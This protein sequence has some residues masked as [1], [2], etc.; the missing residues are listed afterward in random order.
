[1]SK[2]LSILYISSEVEPFAKTGGLADVAGA[3]P[4]VIREF[5]HDIR[6]FLPKYGFVGERKFNI[7]DVI[8]LRD[9][10]VSLGNK[11]ELASIKSSF[12]TNQRIKV[13]VYFFDLPKH[14]SRDGIYFDPNSKKDYPDND[15]RF[16]GFCRGALE[17]LKRLGWKPDI[18][19]CND[20]Q[21]GLIPA[22]LKTIY[23]DDPFFNK[24]KTVFT[25]HN[26][27]YQGVFPKSSFAKTG[28]PDHLFDEEKG[29]AT[30]DV[31][32]FLKAGIQFADVLTTVSNRYAEEISSNEEYGYGLTELLKKRRKDLHGILNG[33][34]YSV[35]DP[36]IDQLIP[37][38]YTSKTIQ[39]KAENKKV[40]LQTFKLPANDSVPVIGI[41][42]RLVDQKGFDLIHDI[43][44]EV[45]K[46]NL[47]LV[48][49]GTGER[50][51]HNFLSELALKYPEKVGVKLTFD[52]DLAHLIEAGSD[53]FL[54]PSRY[55]P[56]GLNQIYSMRYGTIPIV[57]AT[58]GLDDTVEDFDP[59]NGKGTG[60]KFVPYDGRA[61]LQTIKRALSLFQDEKAWNKTIR[62]AMEQDFSWEKSAKQYIALYKKILKK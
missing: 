31:V 32:N 11:T 21:T 26:I 39:E 9:I 58:G 49:L 7:Y 3:F 35:W 5:G 41:I 6:I 54:M 52:N 46:N 1:M 53:M 43:A 50:R 61:L 59:K 13:Q 55:E 62:N 30:G 29:I 34:D 40:L 36:S 47:I 28:L 10:P 48:V 42:S 18:I 25:I 51:Y 4:Q 60:F 8:R 24:V 14:F 20:W 19:H 27:A 12:I 2:S 23:R 33:V 22:Y 38:Q 37:Q 16:I 15:E 57:R 44:D 45:L 17:T 56:C